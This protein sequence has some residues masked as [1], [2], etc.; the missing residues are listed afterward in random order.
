MRRRSLVKRSSR[1]KSSPSSGFFF[2]PSV[3]SRNE[4]FPCYVF[5]LYWSLLF[6]QFFDDLGIIDVTLV[7]VL[8]FDTI[9]YTVAANRSGVS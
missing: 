9:H 2:C 4:K 6:F 1:V 3:M 5:P 7:R 8:L